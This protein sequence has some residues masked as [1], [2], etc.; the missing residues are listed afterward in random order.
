MRQEII[1]TSLEGFLK[2]GIRKMTVQKLVAPLGISTKTVYKYFSNKED[3]LR[4]CLSVHYSRLL[5]Q[6]YLTGDQH[7]NPAKA[8]ENLWKNAFQIDFGVNRIFYHDLNHYYPELQDEILKKHGDKIEATIVKLIIEGIKNG[9][10]LKDLQPR[11]IFEAMTVIYRSLTRS[12]D[13]RKFRIKPEDLVRQ[14]VHVYLRGI[15]TQKGL[16]ELSS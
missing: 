7:P 14:T 13:F 6:T 2:K 8:L 12:N 10:F 3:L 11:L 9:Y 15:C 16:N 4:E 1:A 5:K